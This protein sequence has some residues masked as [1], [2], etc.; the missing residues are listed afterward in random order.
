MLAEY[1][2]APKQHWKSKDTAIYLVLALT[3]QGKT[4][5]QGATATNQLVNINDF[6][7]S[8]V[9]ECLCVGCGRV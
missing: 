7:T 8:Q 4:G 9:R 1:A 2:S 3:V 6:F 5:A